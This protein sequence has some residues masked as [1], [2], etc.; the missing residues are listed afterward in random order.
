MLDKNLLVIVIIPS[1][2]LTMFIIDKAGVLCGR[3]L[4][5]RARPEVYTTKV[6]PVYHLA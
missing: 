6:L 4:H 3:V 1:G 5:V 2:V